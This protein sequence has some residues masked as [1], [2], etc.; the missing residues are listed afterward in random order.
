[1]HDLLQADPQKDWERV[2]PIL[3]EAMHK[4]KERER[5][6]ILMRYFENRPFGEKNGIRAFS[7]PGIGCAAS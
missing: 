5:T 1:M 7:V 2:R 6:A 4:L 3:D